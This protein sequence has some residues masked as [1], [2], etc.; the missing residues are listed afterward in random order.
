MKPLDADQKESNRDQ[1]SASLLITL[2]FKYSIK[3]SEYNQKK[4]PNL[5]KSVSADSHWTF[6][7]GDIKR[8]GD[9]SGATETSAKTTTQKVASSKLFSNRIEN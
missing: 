9:S 4:N 2:A 6:Y 3:L 8:E 1:T 7:W 5:M